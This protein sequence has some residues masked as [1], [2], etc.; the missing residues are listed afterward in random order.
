MSST[1]Y[2]RRE[3]L[4]Q[5]AAET[6]RIIKVGGYRLTKSSH[7]LHT[8]QVQQ[9]TTF[10][11]PHTLSEW[12]LQTYQSAHSQ[13]ASIS[14]LEIST[15]SC[16]RLLSSIIRN[17]ACIDTRIGV[18][19]FASAVKPG[20]GFQNGAQAQEESI[21]RSSNLFP[22]LKTETA[23][24]FYEIHNSE[25]RNHFYT[26]SMIY[27]PGVEVFRDDDGTL[28]KPFRIDVLTSAAV[29]AHEVRQSPQ[30]HL[31]GRTKTE[32]KIEFVMKERMAQ[33][34]F[35]FERRGVRNLVLGSFGTGVFRNDVGVVARIWAELLAPGARFERSF[36]RVFFAILGKRTFVDFG[37][38]FNDRTHQ[39]ASQPY[40][41]YRA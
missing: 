41:P 23:Q 8:K 6:L 25:P 15:L 11:P 36:D 2:H 30:A 38:A 3:S 34:L 17:N 22:A 33:I 28:T 7:S 19:N 35:L 13:L 18:L 27:S 1:E 39:R 40:R 37:N 9:D 5:L 16:A 4:R 10:H 31:L 26:H 32:E 20:G 12:S 14:I 24:N 21:A 29:N